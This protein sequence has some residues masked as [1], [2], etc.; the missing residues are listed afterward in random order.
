MYIFI[1]ALL[2]SVSFQSIG[3]SSNLLKGVKWIENQLRIGHIGSS[4]NV[5]ELRIF[6]GSGI[7][8][9]GHVLVISQTDSLWVGTKYDYFLK[10]KNGNITKKI[11]KVNKTD[12]VAK[13]WNSLW[14]RLEKLDI[15]TLP[16]QADIKYKLK[17]EV[18]TPRGKGYA[19]MNVLDGSVYTL[20]VKKQSL[21]SY[22]SF[23]EPWI[24]SREYPE[25]DEVRKYGE[26][27]ST[28]ENELSLRFHH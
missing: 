20:L 7:T 11:S 10:M 27:I 12:L 5:V 15:L 13:D 16:D 9:G 25:V 23:H 21:I 28:L 1:L 18:D 24:Y 3:Q 22:Y 17:K 19:V 8:N 4:D 26:I 6:L 2:V 14:S